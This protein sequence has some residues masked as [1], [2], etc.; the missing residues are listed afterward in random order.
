[1]KKYFL[2]L[3]IFIVAICAI[4]IASAQQKEIVPGAR[5]LDNNGDH[6]QAHG[7]GI[8]HF[9]DRYYWY[10]EQRRK[11]VEEKNPFHRFV[12]CY[13]STDLMNWRFE[14]DV[15]KLSNPKPDLL[16]DSVPKLRWVLERPKV[17][18][19]KK[20][21]TYVMYMHL[22]GSYKGET[23]GY[24]FAHVGVAT[25]KK[26]TGPFK[27]KRVF[28]PL[29]KESRDI[30]QFIDDDGTAY[31]IFECRPEKG[32]YIA[33]LSD[34]YMDVEEATCFIPSRLEGGAIVKYKGLYYCVGS[35]LTG[36]RP[37]PNKY[38]TAKSLAGPWSEFKDIAPAESNTYSSQS[39]M[40]LKVEGRKDTTVIFLADQWRPLEQHES[41]YLWM[42]VEIG[43]GKLWVPEPQPWSIDV[44][45]GTHTLNGKKTMDWGD[46]GN[47]TYKNPVLLT[48][49]SD[50]DVIRVGKKFYMVAS[51]FHFM[52]MQMLESDDMVNWRYVS[53]V[54]N[55]L[56]Y[57][58]FDEMKKYAGGSW[59]PSLRYHDG[60][61]WVYFCTPHE[62]LFMSQAEKP[63]GPWLPLH[64]VKKAYHWED[65]CP[66]WDED[67]KAYLGRS[68][69]GAGPI[70][71]HRMSADG[72]EL[73]NDGDTIYK[74]PVAEG[75]KIYKIQPKPQS[76]EPAWYYL[77]IPEG[78]VSQGWQTA[79]R[80]K[81]IYGPYERKTVLEQAGTNVNGPHQGALVNIG[82]DNDFS[83]GQWWFYHFQQ[84]GAHGRVVHLQPVR[85]KNDWPLMGEDIDG[86]GRP[87]PVSIY[88]TPLMTNGQSLPQTSGWGLQWQWNHNPVD[89]HWNLQNDVLTLKALPATEF[90]QARNTY[91]QKTMGY[92]SEA[93]VELDFSQV[94]ADAHYGIC[95]M[96]KTNELLEVNSDKM[97]VNNGKIY[98]RVHFDF[99]KKK[100]QFSYSTDGK[101]FNSFG[102]SFYVDFGFWKGVRWGVYHYT[103]NTA[104]SVLHVKNPVYNILK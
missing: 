9:G 92:E 51:D 22:D 46:Q 61:F 49:F 20:T 88:R 26:A 10:G 31:L 2:R 13:S 28:R 36:W 48:D 12:S 64:C 35:A 104:N 38:A 4:S 32:F 66:F 103:E 3:T 87:S 57:P 1:M 91:T 96:G 34:D 19:N 79:L 102:D 82:D 81:N 29:G 23:K 39:T 7:G 94:S 50:P 76:G 86:T 21:K 16:I 89:S 27:L 73:L 72:K 84:K 25:S 75:T 100:Y 59:A 58:G 11:G 15:I 101:N 56:D 67:G 43:N 62:G 99:P 60:K 95:V 17:Y 71:L 97:K 14:G 55:R 63:G 54:Y 80:S 6:I 37:N 90:K 33:K 40:L 78:G 44:K 24:T 53:Q 65:P 30:G 70:I 8:V 85:W 77:L 42:P 5:W 47:L 68:A 74:G 45:N 18:Y 83:D 98:L 69:H 93:T 52:G 41:R